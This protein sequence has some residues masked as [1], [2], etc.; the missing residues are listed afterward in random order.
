MSPI[1][2]RIF[3]NSRPRNEG[4]TRNEQVD[5]LFRQVVQIIP[6]AVSNRRSHADPA[7][8]AGLSE[9]E[10]GVRGGGDRRSGRETISRR[11]VHAV[12]KVH[13]VPPRLGPPKAEPAV[14]I[15]I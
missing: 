8:D 3:P 2:H 9:E 4:G 5:D 14:V 15:R 6:I 1:T 12:K 13:E 11:H 10:K 7:E